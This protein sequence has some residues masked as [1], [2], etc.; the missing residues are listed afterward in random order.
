MRS[1]EVADLAG[2]TVRTLRHYHHMGL[3]PEPPR[4][5]NGY[6]VYGAT[7]VARVLRIKRLASLGISLQQ[8]KEMLDEEGSDAAAHSGNEALDALDAELAERIEHLQEQRRIIAELRERSI[9]PDAPPAFAEHLARLKEAGAGSRFVE[10]ELAGLFLVDRLLATGSEEAESVVQFFE[11]LGESDRTDRYVQ[12]N[13]RLFALPADADEAERQNLADDFVSFMLPLLDRGCERYGW[14]LSRARIEAMAAPSGIDS[15]HRAAG[16][17]EPEGDA[18]DGSAY[19]V[20]DLYD[21]ETLNAAQRD[22][23]ERV[24][25]GVL[26]ALVERVPS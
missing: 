24:S 23:S 8:V 19:D 11:L 4:S 14:D 20:F 1:K 22:M 18:G 9:S 2:V 21:M 12:L 26:R 7:D 25:S 16:P 15:G 3:L 13:E 17:E 5:A 6:R 10:T